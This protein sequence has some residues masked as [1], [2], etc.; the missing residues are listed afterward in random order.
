M[1]CRGERVHASFFALTVVTLLQLPAVS[2]VAR[3]SDALA[4]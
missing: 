4:G 1:P 2:T 3:R